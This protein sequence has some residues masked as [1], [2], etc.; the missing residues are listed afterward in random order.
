[1]YF[2]MLNHNKRSITLNTKCEIEA[3]TIFAKS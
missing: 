3:R 2:T 1:M